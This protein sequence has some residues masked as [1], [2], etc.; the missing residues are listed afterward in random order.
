LT[1]EFLSAG[2]NHPVQSPRHDAAEVNGH[3]VYGYRVVMRVHLV[4]G[5][6]EL[7]RQHFG[8]A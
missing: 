3:A 2:N 5:T 1:N 8:S 6:Y 7:F 4:D